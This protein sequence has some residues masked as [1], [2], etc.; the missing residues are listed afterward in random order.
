MWCTRE[1]CTS[2]PHCI[3]L[4]LIYIYKQYVVVTI[5]IDRVL[6]TVASLTRE[7]SR[8]HLNLSAIRLTPTINTDK[9]STSSSLIKT[10]THFPSV[11]L[12]YV[13]FSRNFFI[14]F[15]ISNCN[16]ILSNMTIFSQQHMN[17]TKHI[18]CDSQLICWFVQAQ[19]HHYFLNHFLMFELYSTCCS[20]CKS[21]CHKNSHLVFL[22][23]PYFSPIYKIC[24]RGWSVWTTISLEIVVGS[25]QENAPCENISLKELHSNHALAQNNL[26]RHHNT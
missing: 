5:E 20:H 10:T 12:F 17:N 9:E 7:G 24:G 19:H 1:T 22:Q 25:K 3:P 15:T 16:D 26:P 14:W 2:T 11:Y 18:A 23:A 21:L 13:L 6:H 4:V 8:I